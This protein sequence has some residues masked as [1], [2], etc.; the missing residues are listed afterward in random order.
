MLSPGVL[1]TPGSLTFKAADLYP[2]SGSTFIIDAVGP[3]PTTI[4]FLPNGASSV[5]LSAGGSLLIDATTIVQ[6]GTIRAPSGT[7]V[8][9][10]RR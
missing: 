5:P 9:W 1:F 8:A 10:R 7:I 2:A 4:T 3:N 6:S